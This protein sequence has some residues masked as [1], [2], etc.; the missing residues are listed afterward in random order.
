MK[1]KSLLPTL[2][3]KKRYITFE[4]IGITNITKKTLTELTT[5]IKSLLGVFESAEAGIML[6]NTTK[7]KIIIRA[8]NKYTDKIIAITTFIKQ[9][10]NEK[11]IIKPILTTGLLD[12]AKNA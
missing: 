10:N 2:K 12:K 11:I 4:I 8:N 1:M 7:N 5:Q 9:L 3:E 6:L